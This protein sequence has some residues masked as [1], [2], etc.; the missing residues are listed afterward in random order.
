MAKELGNETYVGT[1]NATVFVEYSPE[2]KAMI[3]PLVENPRFVFELKKMECEDCRKARLLICLP[4]QTTYVCDDCA[5]V[6]RKEQKK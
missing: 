6:R 4:E 2:L 5:N 1:D 3:R